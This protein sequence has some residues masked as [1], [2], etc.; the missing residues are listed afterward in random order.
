MAGDTSGMDPAWKIDCGANASWVLIGEDG[1][2]R[3]K[4]FP[5]RARCVIASPIGLKHS[6]QMKNEE[7]HARFSAS[8]ARERR[9][10]IVWLPF[11]LVC[12]IWEPA[13]A[14]GDETKLKVGFIA[15]L[16]GP[17]QAYGQAAR[18]GFELAREDAGDGSIQVIYED[19][20]FTPAK[21]IAAFNKLTQLDAVKVV[22][23]VGSATLN[24]IAPLAELRRVPV[25]GWGSDPR[26]SRNRHF[27]IRS[28]PS[29][30]LE[31]KRASEEALQR[32]YSKIGVLTTIHDYPVSWRAGVVATIQRESLRL[33]EQ[34]P[35]DMKDFTPLLLK[36]RHQGVEDFLICIL[37][38][39]VGAFARQ[40]YQMKMSLRIGGCEFLQ[41]ENELKL[42]KGALT[43]AWYIEI[44]VSPDF[45]EKYKRKY[46]NVNAIAGAAIHYDLFQQ[47]RLIAQAGR[48]ADIAKSLMDIR[49]FEGVAGPVTMRND[50]GD[51]YFGYNLEPKAVATP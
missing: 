38:G 40:A 25:I 47:L 19:D 14:K 13:G 5:K 34:V 21:T 51:Q 3:I 6:K 45:V 46:G 22:I 39:Q 12:G 8:T 43:G 41:D 10:L 48:T 42:S 37:P 17:A 7:C 11:I 28:Y 16:S 44:P 1:M 24:A 29:G 23:S 2:Q 20:Q 35:P 31:G 9:G 49:R 32:R 36:A 50:N 27:V 26:A 15:A 33:D 4:D 18:N 30:E